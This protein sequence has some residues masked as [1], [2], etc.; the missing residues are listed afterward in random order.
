MKI[1]SD[2]DLLK[3]IGETLR[4]V[5]CCSRCILRYIGEK[6]GDVYRKT[7]QVTFLF[8]LFKEDYGYLRALSIIFRSVYWCRKL[9]K[10]L[11]LNEYVLLI[12]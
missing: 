10:K 2:A 11:V 3:E 12:W 5:G 7:T 8:I 4:D 9:K 6:Q 1:T